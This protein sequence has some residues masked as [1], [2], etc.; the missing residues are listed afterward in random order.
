MVLPAHNV[1]SGGGKTFYYYIK[2]MQ[3][4]DDF[5][6][7]LVSK[8][9]EDEEF[10]AEYLSR[11]NYVPITNSRLSIMKPFTSIKD[12]FS[13]INPYRKYGNTLRES[14][15]IKIKDY[16]NCHKSDKID[17]IILEFAEMVLLAPYVRELFPNTPIFASEH[18]VTFLGK[19][20]EIATARNGIKKALAK[21]R[22]KV[23]KRCELEALEYCDVIMPHNFKDAR[24]LIDNGISKEKI[25]VLTPYFCDMHIERTPKLRDILF[26]GAMGR[27]E[28]CDAA[29]WFIDNVMPLLTDLD[30]RFVILGGNPQQRILNRKSD[31]IIV[32]G[33][34]DDITP[35]FAASTCLVAPLLN[36]AGIKIKI[37]E[38]LAA[39]IPTLTNSIGIEGIDAVNGQDYFYCEQ[40]Q[41]YADIIRDI[42]DGKI[43]ADA[44]SQNAQQF[45]KRTYNLE[46]AFDAY[47]AR[48]I[49]VV[50]SRRNG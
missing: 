46:A 35:F 7:T 15:Y 16:L 38:A 37:L 20:R 43:D 44:I 1:A 30:I 41:E 40:P 9:L 13:K 25:F 8:Q 2:G 3:D 5:S 42:F 31:R 34:V 19:Q 28:N 6:V 10:D 33:F 27:N 50:E 49:T 22:Y 4:R 45:M 36:G 18:D 14:V 29:I 23:R 32:T 21:I 47:K 24:L 11:V 26:Y 39:G 48:I 17:V 12:I